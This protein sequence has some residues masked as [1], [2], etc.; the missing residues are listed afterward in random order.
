[1]KHISGKLAI[2]LHA[3]NE[4]LEKAE[5]L[6][7]K[8]QENSSFPDFDTHELALEKEQLKE[9]ILQISNGLTLIAS[10]II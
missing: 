4:V 8:E 6:E 2:A 9:D 1:M 3:L 10:S 5:M 7:N